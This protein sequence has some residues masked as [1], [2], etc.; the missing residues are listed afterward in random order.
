[1]IDYFIFYRFKNSRGMG[2]GNIDMK[3]PS[4]I[5]SIERLREAE[6]ALRKSLVKTMPADTTIVI[7]NWKR[8]EE[9]A[10]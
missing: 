1:M 10:S 9:Q 6:E 8:F 3:C 5:S 4:P 7:E 2:Y